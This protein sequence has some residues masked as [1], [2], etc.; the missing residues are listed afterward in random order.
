MKQGKTL[1]ELAA[2]LE[3]QQGAKRDFLTDTVHPNESE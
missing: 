2:E 1:V 3:H